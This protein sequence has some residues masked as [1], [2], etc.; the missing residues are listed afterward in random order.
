MR[1]GVRMRYWVRV[2]TSEPG[3]SLDDLVTRFAREWLE[4]AQPAVGHRLVADPVLVLGAS[5]TTPV[6]RDVFLHHVTQ[7]ADAATES[8]THLGTVTAHALGQIMVLAT[9]TWRFTQGATSTELVS[10]F[11]L[12][13]TAGQSLQCVAYLPRT[14][15]MDHIRS[16]A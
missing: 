6:P 12:Q 9:I 4:V 15:V 14:N 3:L 16:E 2:D 10:D 13:R 7:R 1:N 11:L 5:G 8:A